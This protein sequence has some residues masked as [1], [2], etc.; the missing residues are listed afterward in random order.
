[1]SATFSIDR[2]NSMCTFTFTDGRHCRTPRTASH[3]HFCTYHARK[4]SQARAVQ[5][6]GSDIAYD[7]SGKTT[8]ANDLTAALSHL[9]AAVAQGH[10]KPKSANTLAYLGQTLVQSI[11]LAKLEFIE[12]FGARD[13]H[14]EVEAHLYPPEP[15][16]PEPPPTPDPGPEP[17]AESD[18]NPEPA[19]PPDS[20]PDP[21]PIPEAHPEPAAAQQQAQ[22]SEPQLVTQPARDAEPQSNAEEDLDP[23]SANHTG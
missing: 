3:Q 6:L 15:P 16:K 14:A 4:E 22:T 9:F 11:Q 8:T 20:E 13:W 12:A 2:S 18:P 21:D 1:M 17:T 19:T 10:V 7:L 5:K 23:V